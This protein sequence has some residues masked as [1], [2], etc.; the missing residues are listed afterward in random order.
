MPVTCHMSHVTCQVSH[1]LCPLSHVICHLCHLSLQEQPQQQTL[2]WK[3]EKLPKICQNYQRSLINREAWLP[4]CFARENQHTQK[5]CAA[6]L[7]HFQAKFSNLR[8]ILS[9]TFLQGFGISKTI[10]YCT[11]GSGL[12]KTFKRY[13]KKWTNTRTDISTKRLNWPRGMIQ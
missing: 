7:D 6:I 11:S 3:T 2:P 5:N 1:V 12:K 10:A 9:I 4:P 13:L 8:T